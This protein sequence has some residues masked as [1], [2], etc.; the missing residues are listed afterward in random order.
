MSNRGWAAVRELGIEEEI[1]KIA[2]PLYKRAI[3]INGQGEGL[4]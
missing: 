2:I 3:H 1:K 4:C